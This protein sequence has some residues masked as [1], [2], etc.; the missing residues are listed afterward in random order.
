[1]A[2]PRLPAVFVSLGSPMLPLEPG[3][4]PL[5]PPGSR[6]FRFVNEWV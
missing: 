4:A 3:T 2:A 6:G 1:M 5:Y